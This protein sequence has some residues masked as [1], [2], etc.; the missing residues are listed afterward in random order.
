M[1]G[2]A[3]NLIKFTALGLFTVATSQA[4]AAGY[5][6]EFQSTS[7][8]ADAGEAAVVEDAGTNW[9]N[10]AGLVRLPHQ[11]VGSVID[12]STRTQFTGSICAPNPG[13]SCAPGSTTNFSAQGSAN[14]NLLTLLPA[15]HYSL[16]IRDRYAF[17]VSVVPAW[18]LAEN[19]GTSSFTRYELTR[20]YTKTVDI[21]PSVAVRVNDKWSLGAGP[22]FNYLSLQSRFNAN[23]TGLAPGDAV[24]RVSAD[25]WNTGWHAGAL[26]SPCEGTRFGMNY[27]SKIVM[28]LKGTSGLFGL[29]AGVLPTPETNSFTFHWVLPPITTLSAYH[30]F[31][32][33]WALMGTIAYDQWATLR[34]YNA[35]NYMSSAGPVPVTLYQGF[36]NTFDFGVGAHYTLNEKWMLRGNLKYEPT[37]TSTLHRDINFPDADKLGVQIGS[38]YQFN[39]KLALDLVYGHVFTKSTP[40]RPEAIVNAATQ[41]P[42]TGVTINGHSNTSIDL[43]GAQLVWNI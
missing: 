15:I 11:L 26:F 39:K 6:M 40:I 3:Q 5:K 16:P 29:P 10:A 41:A 30:D 23:A 25:D 43:V 17:G 35:Q 20:I 7:I 21:A 32:N 2:F 13:G 34:N 37:P 36:R 22:D 4:L 12:L 14:S 42:L 18:G 27:R 1:K 9:Y 28:H 19:Y 33:R 24:S 8:I 38:R 31:N